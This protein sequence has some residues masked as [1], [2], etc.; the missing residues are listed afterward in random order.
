M[1]S[2][3][4]D[5]KTNK[6]DNNK[7]EVSVQAALIQ[8]DE[9]F[10]IG[11]FSE[12]Y[13]ALSSFKETDDPEVLWRLSRALYNMSKQKGTSKTDKEA[14]IKEAYQYIEKALSLNQEHYAIHKW[15]AILI[16]AKS[17]LESI[18]SR[19]NNLP[20]FK[21]HLTMA[22]ELNPKDAT[23]IYML[24]QYMYNIADMSWLQL[25]IAKTLFGTPPEASFE[26]AFY[27]FSRAEEVEPNFYSANLLMLG[28]TCLKLK[29]IEA[30]QYWLK[31]A[32]SYPV[33]TDEDEAVR[34]EAEAL[35]KKYSTLKTEVQA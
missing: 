34:L 21:K 1:E 13:N 35:L 25:T 26:E 32:T 22:I 9:L 2:I 23:S 27:Y 4:V 12:S 10:L 33:R 20:L 14:Q 19:I 11:K 29:R 24:G 5:D 7:N 3:K 28:K 6:N 17:A 18:K 31:C 30:A 8:S 16:D 15:T